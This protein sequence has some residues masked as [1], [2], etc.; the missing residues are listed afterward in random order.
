MDD[1]KMKEDNGTMIVDKKAYQAN[2]RHM[3]W[4][5]LIMM[6][7]TTAATIWQ[8]ERMEAAES[9]LMAQYLSLSSLVGAY[10]VIGNKNK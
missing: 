2:R 10:F 8:P 6:L 3:C 1:S 9:I 5:A 7:L 4:C